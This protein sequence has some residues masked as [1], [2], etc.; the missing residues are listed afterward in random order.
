MKSVFHRER[1]WV[2][3]QTGILGVN[4]V[5]API[6]ALLRLFNNHGAFFFGETCHKFQ[7]L[8]TFVKLKKY[9]HQYM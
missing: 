1:Q 8:I 5:C 9:I 7:G 2:S 4:H 3:K 6:F